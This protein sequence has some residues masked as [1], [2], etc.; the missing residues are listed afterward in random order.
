MQ[1]SEDDLA[2]INALQIAPR[3]S[4]TDAADILGVHATTLA[5]RWE[6]LRSSGAAWITAHL[7]GE[8]D[9]MSLS[10]LDVQ[11][12]LNRRS[13][14]IDAACAIPEIVTVDEAARNRD[15]ILTVI[16]PTLA[17]L[18]QQV[19]PAL[20]AI[21]GLN[22]YQVSLCTRLH[23]GGDNW[24]LNI[25]TRAQQQQFGQRKRTEAAGRDP[26]PAVSPDMIRMLM[27]DGRTTAA[28]MSRELGGHPA[29]VRRQL[30]RL[31]ASHLL[32]F[33]CELAQAYSGFPVTCHWFGRVPADRH[34]EVARAL[35][36][37]R[38]VRL[39][40]STTGST[41]F[42]VGM[43]LRSVADVI[44]AE[45]A[46]AERVPE[47][48]LVESAVILN[49]PKRVGWLLEPNGKATGVVVLPTGP[50]DLAVRRPPD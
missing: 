40:A 19:I 30:D 14:V 23:L 8:P 32:T 17:E 6:R 9:K 34:D 20:A 25:L 15:L 49:S 1:L 18:S 38:N 42:M 45:L 12:D 16:T 10:F 21:P 22:R 24:R 28:Q 43:W 37:F 41:N 3:V 39:I 13:P 35:G 7:I 26:F 48:H 31:L 11:C 44:S 33:R 50:S 5:S 29:T 47:L 27:R 2:L 36:S 46:M 4:W